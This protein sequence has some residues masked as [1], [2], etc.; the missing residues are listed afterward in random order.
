MPAVNK[1]E[2]PAKYEIGDSSVANFDQAQQLLA[3]EVSGVLGY[4][5]GTDMKLKLGIDVIDGNLDP[6]T[7]ASNMEQLKTF[8]EKKKNS[9]LSQTSV[10]GDPAV[11]GQQNDPSQDMS[12]SSTAPASPPGRRSRTSSTGGARR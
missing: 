9:L 5:S 2:L 11:G 6:A 3:D 7:F 12:A 1:I 10:Y 4:G 8:L